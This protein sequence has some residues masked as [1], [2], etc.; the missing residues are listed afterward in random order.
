[1]C[2]DNTF[3][4]GGCLHGPVALTHQPNC[5]LCSFSFKI[6]YVGCSCEIVKGCVRCRGHGASHILESHSLALKRQEQTANKRENMDPGQLADGDAK[7]Q[8]EVAESQPVCSGKQTNKNNNNPTTHPQ[9]PSPPAY[10]PPVKST[11]R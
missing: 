2:L 6:G 5:P 4:G 11:V 8:A 10:D 7:S 9:T 1:M 3:T